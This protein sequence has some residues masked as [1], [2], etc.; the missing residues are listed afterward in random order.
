MSERKQLIPEYG[1]LQGVRVLGLGSLVAMPH[2][3][4]MM[5]DF[6]AEFIQIERPGVGDNLR[7]LAP[8]SDK[9]K[10]SN[11]WMQDAR[12]RL[13]ITLETNLN[14]PEVKEL[15]LDLVKEVDILME[16]MVWLKKLGIHDEE[17]LEANPKLVIAH[18]SG[19]GREEFGGEEGVTGRAS[20]DM[21]GQAY[22]GFLHLNGDPDCPPTIVKPYTNDYISGLTALFGVMAA[23]I[24]AQKTGKGQVVDVAQYEAMARM[25]SDTFVTYTENKHN[26]MRCGS[27]SS[28]F[29]PYGLYFDKNGEYVVVGAFGKSVYYRFIESVG[30][31]PDYFTYEEAGN[32]VDALL[33]DK[34]KELDSK[35]KEW[36]A[37]RTAKDI[38][39]ILNANRVP[40][41]KVNKAEDAV[42]SDH[43]N[44]RNNFVTYKDETSG[45]EVKAF[46]V[47]PHMSETPGEIWRGAPR[48]GQ[49]NDLV[50]KEMLGY[51]DEKLATLKEKGYI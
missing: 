42:K 48:I 32:G 10:V 44:N 3:A 50:Y 13:S 1:P 11:S 23:Y 49:D 8:F 27:N 6:G 24:H 31:D 2:A 12:N 41:S 20:F 46:G 39:D 30:F 25:L 14:Y 51:S 33:S 18:I 40:A 21:I 38:E 9:T 43:Y 26:Q 37:A 36:C 19:F 29:Q 4:N 7:H 17:L 47:I 34:G 22:S 35:I 45:E 15:F 28:A 5:A 16:N